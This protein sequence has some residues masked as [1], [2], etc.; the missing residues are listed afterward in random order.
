MDKVASVNCRETNYQPEKWETWI[1][2]FQT[3]VPNKS[4]F[5][6]IINAFLSSFDVPFL[7]VHLF[8]SR[9][10]EITVIRKSAINWIK[11]CNLRE[12]VLIRTDGFLLCVLKYWR[13][14]V[15]TIWVLLHEHVDVSL[16]CVQNVSV[17]MFQAFHSDF[18]CLSINVDPPRCT[19][20]QECPGTRKMAETERL[21]MWN[22][23]A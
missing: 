9:L 15:S 18:H 5:A 2:V 3:N 16:G 12:L 23:K 1:W 19:T 6:A 13:F 10:D 22:E 20:S 17:W 4:S 14:H 11:I 8:F 7:N 21:K